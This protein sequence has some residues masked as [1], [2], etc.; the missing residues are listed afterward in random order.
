L[1]A[2]NIAA[3]NEASK[4]SISRELDG[5][6]SRYSV[7]PRW[8][9]EPGPSAGQIRTAVQA[10][11]RAPDHGSLVPWRAV[12]VAQQDRAALGELFAQCAREAGKDADYIAI[13]RSRAQHGPVLVAWVARI[14]E[15]SEAA[16]PHEQWI[17]VGGALTNFLNAVHLMGFAAKALSGRKCS[18]PALRAAFCTSAEET[19][20][21]FVCVGTAAKALKPR[22]VDDVDAALS[23]WKAPQQ[24]E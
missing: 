20:V 2:G 15:N 7:G 1:N 22:L 24:A 19:L 9:A 14:A 23:Y 12:V 11:L 3:V 18:H 16:P 5:L 8:L 4:P 17:A 6:L 21:G 13:E 10:A